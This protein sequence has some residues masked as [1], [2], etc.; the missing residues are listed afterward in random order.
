MISKY[1]NHKLQTDRKY[2][3]EEPH[4]NHKT[5]GRQ[6]KQSIEMIAK[7]LLKHKKS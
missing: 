3:E 2:R 5:P 6:T 7:L 4:I 1:H